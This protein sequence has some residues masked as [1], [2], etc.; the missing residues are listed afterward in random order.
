MGPPERQSERVY[1]GR[2]AGN[3]GLPGFL[4]CV[5]GL[6]ADSM[7]CRRMR[8]QDGVQELLEAV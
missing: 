1:P 5:R 6:C 8:L 2:F 4:F 7:G 3:A